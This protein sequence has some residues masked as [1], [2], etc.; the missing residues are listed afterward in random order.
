MDKPKVPRAPETTRA[1]I[2]P[3]RA[4]QKRVAVLTPSH[5]VA[6]MLTRN[7]PALDPEERRQPQS[8]GRG[9]RDLAITPS[10]YNAEARTVE[11]ILSSGAAVRRY[12]F[13]EELEISDDAIDLSRVTAGVCSLLDTHQQYSLENK[14][15]MIVSARVENGQLIGVFS[16]ADTPK[17]REIEARVAAGEVRAISVGYRVTRWQIS[18]TDDTGH[19][20]WRAVAWELL[21]ASFVS[22]PA[23]PNAVVRSAPSTSPHGQQQEDD[24][25]RNLPG[26]TAAAA[27][28]LAATPAPGEA[29]TEP[30][31]A[32]PAA[33]AE[34][35]PGQRQQAPAAPATVTVAQIRTAATNAGL[36]ADAAFE[37]IERH[38]AT[39]LTRDALMADIGTRFAERDSR[40][41]T[42]NR[43]SVTRDA[44]DTMRRGMGDAIL[45]RMSAG[46]ALTD[47]GRQYRGMSLVRMAEDFL[48]SEGVA[49]RGMTPNEIA[50]RALH[51]GSDF[52]A[53]MANGMNRRLRAAYEENMP[54]YQRWARRAPSAPNFKSIDVVQLSALPD[55]LR[56][57]EGGEVKFGAM[58][59]GI[60]SYRV[61]TY[62]RALGITRQTIVNDD[63][64]A[65]ERVATGFSAAARR[66]ENR[67]VYS[68]LTA[69]AN[70]PDGIA[71][72]AA[73]HGNLA[74]AGAVISAT[75]LGAG[76]AAMRKQK[77]LQ[78]EELNL[79]PAHIIVPTDQEQLA[80]Q[81]TSSQ[82]VPAKT[83][84]INEFRAGGRTALE[85]IVE[86]VL[87]A[88]STTRWYL[89]ANNADVDT[90]EY[91]YL[92]GTEGVQMA[93][94]LGF[95]VDG[96]KVKAT[97]D[98][99][100][101]VIDHRGLYANPGA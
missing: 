16:F 13:T 61:V 66:L 101:A 6:A 37:L 30:V 28:A 25:K 1:P 95:D 92:E 23:D 39:P 75:T 74:G 7:A 79:A 11:A 99:A 45:H 18:Q 15:G 86:A 51:A 29:R 56:V 8:G 72:F 12:Y 2:A 82:F 70:M 91:C 19:E 21:E 38:E 57:N 68:Q 31:A 10:S 14:I 64:R 65:L 9:Q 36:D 96:V 26:A 88:N 48:A 32:A 34:T 52:P 43:I 93:S 59:D 81:F 4:K 62:S 84:D 78:N 35:A 94:Q 24:M 50:E 60:V 42:P 33:S 41:S 27:P 67:T 5:A 63:L 97:L 58:S 3:D 49:V 89:A 44:G 73:G 100:A 80:Y 40:A 76:R 55:L 83:T 98:F 90:V 87:D 22:V 47:I 53:L 17:A 54:S 69:N 77:G 85:P 71:L 46:T 20:T